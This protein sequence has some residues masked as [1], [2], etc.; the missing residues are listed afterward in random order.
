MVVDKGC[1][2]EMVVDKDVCERGGGKDG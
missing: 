2:G 1:V